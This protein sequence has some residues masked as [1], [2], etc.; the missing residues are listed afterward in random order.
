MIPRHQRN[1]LD[2]LRLEA[3]EIAVLDQVVRMFMVTLVADMD[4]DIVKDRRVL[5]PL[6]LAIRQ[7]VNGARLIEQRH[8]QSCHLL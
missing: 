1:N 6:A 5:E 3:A 2:F 8:S 7:A 4:A